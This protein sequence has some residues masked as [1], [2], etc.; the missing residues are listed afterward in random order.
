M[1]CIIYVDNYKKNNLLASTKNKPNSKLTISKKT[2]SFMKMKLHAI[3]ILAACVFAGSFFASCSR[4][5][6]YNTLPSI[7]LEAQQTP[8]MNRTYAEVEKNNVTLNQ[9]AT[10]ETTMKQHAITFKKHE[11]KITKN[12]GLTKLKTKIAAV[13]TKKA[14]VSG[15][16]RNFA[17]AMSS[18]KMDVKANPNDGL[19]SVGIVF[20]VF[21]LLSFLIPP[22]FL[23]SLSVP[24]AQMLIAI[25]IILVVVGLLF[26]ATGLARNA[27]K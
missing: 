3:R 25:A 1:Y 8:D 13:T 12:K 19:A 11:V 17:L 7:Q 2:R 22:L 27:E 21:G 15:F 14:I 24:G 6:A 5:T 16:E 26:M 10:A 20:L 23:T 9:V 4:Q 18:A